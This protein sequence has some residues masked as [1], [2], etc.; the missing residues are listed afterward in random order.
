VVFY[1]I[2]AAIIVTVIR[3]PVKFSNVALAKSNNS[4]I[5]L[6]PK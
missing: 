1:E 4:G 5:L 2:E 6:I 3:F